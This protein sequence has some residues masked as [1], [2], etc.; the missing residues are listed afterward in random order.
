MVVSSSLFSN[1]LMRA[2]AGAEG[3]GLVSHGGFLSGN[4]V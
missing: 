4:A 3:S 1:D 2:S